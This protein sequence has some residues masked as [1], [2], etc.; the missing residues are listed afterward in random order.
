MTSIHR[1]ATRLLPV[2]LSTAFLLCQVLNVLCAMGPVAMAAPAIHASPLSHSAD[3]E[4]MCPDS[5]S[6]SSG[7]VGSQVPTSLTSVKDPA[8]SEELT[9]AHRRH[10]LGEPRSPSD[11]PL[12][13]LLST[14]R[15]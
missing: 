10:L 12:F 3:A 13:A 6:S 8:A 5:L 1:R 7:Q 2:G 11:L 4:T 14:F 9:L 15:I